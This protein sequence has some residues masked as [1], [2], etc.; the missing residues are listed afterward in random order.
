ML[1]VFMSTKQNHRFN[2]I[3]VV[4]KVILL[5]LK[6]TFSLF[7]YDCPYT[8]KVFLFSVTSIEAKFQRT[9]NLHF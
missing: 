9:I 1:L 4:E 7:Y 3:N 5:Q 8:E 2:R 6:K